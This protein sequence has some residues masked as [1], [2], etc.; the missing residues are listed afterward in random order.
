MREAQALAKMSPLVTGRL[1][2]AV[3]IRPTET[4]G[5]VDGRTRLLVHRFPV[6]DR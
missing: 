1:P 6:V 5:R 4:S 3:G 2:D